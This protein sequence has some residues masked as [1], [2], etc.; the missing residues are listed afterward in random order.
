MSKVPSADNNQARRMLRS[1]LVLVAAFAVIGF[2]PWV[3]AEAARTTASASGAGHGRGH[4]KLLFFAADG[5]RQDAVEKYA[6]QGGVP[7]FRELLRSG[8]RGV[9]QRPA[10]PG[11]AEH[12]R[13][14]VHARD[15]RVAGR[16]RVDQQHLPRERPAVRQPHGRV[17]RRRA[18]GRDARPV[19]RARRQ[20]GR[21]DR[22]GR[23]PQRR[24]QRPDARLPQLPLR[25]RRGHELHLADRLGGVRHGRSGCSSTI[26][27]GSPASAPFPQAAPAPATGWTDVPQS[28]SPAQEMRLRVLDVGVD[29]YGLNAYIYDS[30]DDGRTRYDRVLFSPT[31][32]GDDAVGD[33]REGEWA[34][35][36]V[37]IQG[38]NLDGKTGAL[39]V[40]V[41]R[42]AARPLAGPAVPHLG[43][44]RDRDV[45]DVAGRARASPATSRTSSPSASRPR[46][47]ATSPS[48]R[49]ASSARRPTS[50][51]ACTGRPAYRPLI[52]YVLDTYKPDLAMV[53][54]PVTDEFQHQFLGPRH[55]QAAQRRR[56]PGLRRRPGQRHAR[57]PRRGARGVHPARVRGRRRDDAP[58]PEAAARPR[59]DDVR[60]LRPRLRPAVRRHRREQGARRPR[61][62]V[63][64]ADV[65]LPPGDAA[66][67]SA[68]RRPAGPAA[69]CRSTSTSPGATRPTAG[70][71]AGRGRR[72]GGDGRPRSRRRSSA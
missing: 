35:V 42:L 36:K 59:P 54:Y 40:K 39:L 71:P 32:D 37:T 55:A 60:R 6:D 23:R 14:L 38:S 12:R 51:R 10:H 22:V 48:S 43:H 64:A 15:R 33:L 8:A 49:P 44:P 17:R 47:P 53:G 19:G 58:G 50:S 5:L 41:E 34:D 70:L 45:A 57:R 18:P 31:K 67:R 1:V 27:P 21:P 11:A 62:A 46:R 2:V 24:H 20:E 72:R 69:R 66:R 30:R 9:R 28:Y 29:K 16:A 52:K 7:G 25:P 13:R 63:A 61:P 68:R 3:G 56:Q 65:E 4:D 26:R